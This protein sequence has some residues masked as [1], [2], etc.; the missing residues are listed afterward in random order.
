MHLHRCGCTLKHS[1]LDFTHSGKHCVLG[2]WMP[3]CGLPMQ[4]LAAS[5]VHVLSH[6]HDAAEVGHH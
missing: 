1:I 4:C 2:I 3:P 6:L 5:A